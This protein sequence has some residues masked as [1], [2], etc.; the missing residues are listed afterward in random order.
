MN[1]NEEIQYM[2]PWSNV[3]YSKDQ[4]DE[5]VAPVLDVIETIPSVVRDEQGKVKLGEPTIADLLGSYPMTIVRF[6]SGIV[7]MLQLQDDGDE[8]YVIGKLRKFHELRRSENGDVISSA[9]ESINLEPL[10]PQE[11]NRLPELVAKLERT[12]V[13]SLL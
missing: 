11:L 10:Y 13:P 1:N 2:D 9:N 5:L 8:P 12:E 6:R 7:L 3:Q 4:H